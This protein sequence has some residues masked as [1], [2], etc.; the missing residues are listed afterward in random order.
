[1]NS[2]K[3]IPLPQCRAVFSW[4][5]APTPGPSWLQGNFGTLSMCLGFLEIRR[6][7]LV[8][9]L[10]QRVL[11]FRGNLQLCR[12]KQQIPFERNSTVAAENC[13]SKRLCWASKLVHG[14]RIFY[15]VIAYLLFFIVFSKSS[16]HSWLEQLHL[17]YP[18][19]WYKAND[20]I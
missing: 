14:S 4:M 17:I 3:S 16:T 5:T 12:W 7:F 9:S 10:G 20:V 15:F 8:N 2:F 13:P 1:M 18:I 11:G 6:E 19:I